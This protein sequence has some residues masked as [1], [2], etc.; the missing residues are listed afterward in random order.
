MLERVMA[1]QAGVWSER[2]ADGASQGAR[3]HVVTSPQVHA[4]NEA[5]I[6]TQIGA[7]IGTDRGQRAAHAERSIATA[8]SRHT[9]GHAVA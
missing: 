4:H 3:G 2:S 1:G 5:L 7:L 8:T 6:L 9:H